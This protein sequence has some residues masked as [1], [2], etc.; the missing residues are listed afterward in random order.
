MFHVVTENIQSVYVGL[1]H[2]ISEKSVK[3]TGC[4]SLLTG[5][6]GIFEVMRYCLSSS[7]KP[8]SR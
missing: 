1:D 2:L 4:V 7:R 6:D 3:I 5:L 8:D